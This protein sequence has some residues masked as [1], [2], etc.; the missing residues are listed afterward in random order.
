MRLPDPD[1]IWTGERCVWG[2]VR[3]F[4]LSAGLAIM[5]RR[6]STIENTIARSAQT[7]PLGRCL[8]R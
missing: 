2:I 1:A 4:W 7:E 6:Q 3:S 5:Q 8:A